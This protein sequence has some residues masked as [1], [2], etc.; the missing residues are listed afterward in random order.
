MKLILSLVALCLLAFG[1]TTGDQSRV[2]RSPDRKLRAVVVT[3]ATG[4]SQIDIQATP[5]SVL[6]RRDERSND[7]SHGHGID[8]AAWTSDSQF[9]VASTSASGGH[10]PWARPLWVYSRA[11]NRVFELSRFGITATTDFKL[12]P[13]DIVLTTAPGCDSENTPRTIA[14]SL[15]R[16]VSTRR[17][18]AAP[19]SNQ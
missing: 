12:K 17:I 19:C 2:Y 10:Q 5:G 18:P 6:L 3:G 9:F 13:P 1:Q 15:H 11:K 7:G 8:Q 4:E 14:F 16:L